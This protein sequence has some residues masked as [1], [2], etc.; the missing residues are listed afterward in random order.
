MSAKSMER[1]SQVQVWL[2][3]LAVIWSGEEWDRMF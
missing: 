1:K 3:V 2:P